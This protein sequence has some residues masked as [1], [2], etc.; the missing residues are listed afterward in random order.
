VHDRRAGG[1]TVAALQEAG[2]TSEKSEWSINFKGAS[3]VSVQ[4]SIEDFYKAFPSRAVVADVHGILM[5]VASCPIH[6]A[7]RANG[8]RIWR[9]SP[10]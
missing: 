6:A 7:E 9:I 10:V 8:K 5:R 2:F 1:E 4:I 3:K